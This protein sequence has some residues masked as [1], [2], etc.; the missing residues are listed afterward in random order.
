[1]V[2]YKPITLSHLNVSPIS[3]LSSTFGSLPRTTAEP[4][5]DLV[6]LT[7]VTADEDILDCSAVGSGNQTFYKIS[8]E[9]QKN[10]P[11]VMTFQARWD[12]IRPRGMGAHSVRRN[13]APFP[14]MENGRLDF[15]VNGVATVSK[16]P[17]SLPYMFLLFPHSN[18]ARKIVINGD[19][20]VR[21]TIYV[22]IRDIRPPFPILTSNR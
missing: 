6:R 14:Q 15:T 20:C 21:D 16:H 11:M 17:S 8:T 22:R 3:S 10:M 9:Y 2:Q 4:S 18:N 1:M 13:Q 12:T 5:L 19:E 7:F